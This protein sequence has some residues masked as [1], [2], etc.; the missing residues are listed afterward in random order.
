MFEDKNKEIVL[1][2][3]T[4]LA[5]TVELLVLLSSVVEFLLRQIYI[6]S[7]VFSAEIQTKSTSYLYSN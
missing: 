4:Y 6:F 2:C 7:P 1:N 5:V 3:A